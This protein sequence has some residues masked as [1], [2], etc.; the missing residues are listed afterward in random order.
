M[1]K[2]SLRMKILH[3]IFHQISML[4]KEKRNLD[5]VICPASC[6]AT[7]D[8]FTSWKRPGYKS[9]T[10]T[11]TEHPGGTSTLPI[12]EQT[13]IPRGHRY[14]SNGLDISFH[15]F[16]QP[17]AFVLLT[18][19]TTICDSLGPNQQLCASPELIE[20]FP[21]CLIWAHC[22]RGLCSALN[23]LSIILYRQALN[24]MAIF[25]CHILLIK[26]SVNI[27]QM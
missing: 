26:N 15:Q 21:K 1:S 10:G 3:W 16:P 18:N 22:V 11:I 9:T 27:N 23:T 19:I 4:Y 8:S 12:L 14:L 2:E 6:P 25:T 5:R 7:G 24:I 20:L 17:D 13:D